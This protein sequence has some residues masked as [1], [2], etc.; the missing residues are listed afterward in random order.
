[1]KNKK[2]VFVKYILIVVVISIA[3]VVLYNLAMATGPGDLPGF[4]MVDPGIYAGARPTEKGV[5]ILKQKG[6]RS[7]L[8]LEEWTFVPNPKQI[9]NERAWAARNGIKFI[10]VPMRPLQAPSKNQLDRAVLEV[11]KK[12]NRPIYIH[13]RQ[14]KDRTGMV[15]AVY[16]IRVDGWSTD[17]AY[18]EMK[19]R[20][21]HTHRLFW[22]KWTLFK[23]TNLR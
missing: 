9:V 23:Y 3:A 21:F 19:A 2:F 20:G 17:K 10:R 14:G 4:R 6:I 1:M 12:A 18:E 11:L 13:C 16:R 8:D 22:W 7:I 5:E 15:V